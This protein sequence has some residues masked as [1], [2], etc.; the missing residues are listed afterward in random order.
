MYSVFFSSGCHENPSFN[1]TQQNQIVYSSN[2]VRANSCWC[3]FW[4]DQIPV[5]AT[6]KK[7]NANKQVCRCRTR[8]KHPVITFPDFIQL[9]GRKQQGRVECGQNRGIWRQVRSYQVSKHFVLMHGRQTKIPNSPL[10]SIKNENLNRIKCYG[11]TVR[12]CRFSVN[13]R[14]HLYLIR[15]LASMII[16]FVSSRF[17]SIHCYLFPQFQFC[18]R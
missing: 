10:N 12:N 6:K 17:L 13:R 4:S 16:F 1:P 5:L 9:L 18:P 8:C 7:R 2:N 11:I 3:A 14:R 15:W